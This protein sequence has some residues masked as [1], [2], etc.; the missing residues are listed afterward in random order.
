MRRA[1]R[2]FVSDS[3]VSVISMVNVWRKVV[4]HLSYHFR[5]LW[6]PNETFNVLNAIIKRKLLDIRRRWP[7][8]SQIQCAYCSL[9]RKII[10]LEVRPSVS[11]T[12]EAT[13]LRRLTCMWMYF[14]NPIRGSSPFCRYSWEWETCRVVAS[15]P[16][17]SECRDLG[18]T[19]V[20]NLSP[21]PNITHYRNCR[22]STSAGQYYSLLFHF[23]WY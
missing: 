22:K 23:W 19:V 15:M 10:V 17:H 11:A 20:S 12:A 13:L 5:Q 16:S 9:V 8:P 3:W 21:F 1:L 4:N 18:I 7:P 6:F 2:R 14:G